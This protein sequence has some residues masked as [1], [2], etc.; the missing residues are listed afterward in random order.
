[1]TGKNDVIIDATYLLFELSQSSSPSILQVDPVASSY[2][3]KRNPLMLCEVAESENLAITLPLQG[4]ES[5]CC[6][7]TANSALIRNGKRKI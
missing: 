5:L 2:Q 4:S 7:E 6:P 1:M 3:G